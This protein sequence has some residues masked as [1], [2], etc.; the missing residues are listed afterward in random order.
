MDLQP[1]ITR[2]RAA[3]PGV[4]AF[5]PRDATLR[6]GGAYALVIGLTAP[7]TFAQGRIGP[8]VLDGVL[9]YAG[10]A[11]GP[12]GMA[13]RIGRHLRRDKPVK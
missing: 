1:A 5:D 10:S 2:V 9:V 13:A 6:A 7:L 8:S 11:Y 4:V 12:G 3:I